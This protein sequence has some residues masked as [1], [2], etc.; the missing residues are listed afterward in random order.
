MP[1]FGMEDQIELALEG[2]DTGRGQQS[3]GTCPS[4]AANK[5]LSIIFLSIVEAIPGVPSRVWDA[6]RLFRR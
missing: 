5:I 3:R 6:S 2:D 1:R 4:L